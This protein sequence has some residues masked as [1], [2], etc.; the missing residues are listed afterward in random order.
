M[1]LL[2]DVPCSSSLE[3]FSED[4][5]TDGYPI[6]M[7]TFV[8]ICSSGLQKAQAFM[9]YGFFHYNELRK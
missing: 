3:P 6:C 1:E 5:G 2:L 7:S 4:N 9:C 8:I